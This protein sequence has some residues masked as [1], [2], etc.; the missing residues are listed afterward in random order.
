MLRKL[1]KQ[2]RYFKNI[3]KSQKGITGL[4]TAIIL[5]AFV[6]VA[7]VFAYTVLSA[8][9]F[10]TQKSQEAV[11]SGLQQT[12]S[13]LELKGSVLTN[14]LAIVNSCDTTT[15]WTAYNSLTLGTSTGTM[16]TNFVETAA[17]LTGLTT[18]SIAQNG[19]LMTHPVGLMTGLKTG[20]T[21][22][23]W[24][25]FAGT[26]GLRSSVSFGLSTADE[27]SGGNFQSHLT[28]QNVFHPADNAWHQYTVTLGTADAAALFY[29]VYADTAYTYTAGDTV[30][31][32]DIEINNPTDAS[33]LAGFANRVI[34]TLGLANGGQPID[35]TEGTNNG[36][37]Q[38]GG[39]NKI[40][41]NFNDDKQQVSDLYWT[42]AFIGSHNSANMLGPG[43]KVQITAYLDYVNKY[44]PGQA[45][46]LIANR[47]FTMEIKTTN[48]AMLTVQ[49]TMP[50]RVHLIDNLN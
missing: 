16:G 45:Y 39:I 50:V 44:A 19:A 21:L 40:V 18:V 49:R 10:S 22:T 46:K 29:G 30:Y 41:V 9:L 4:E 5:I 15:G 6:V 33:S 14:G 31:I 13:T 43:E 3:Y 27:T 32:D 37:V 25:K 20:D 34:F 42:K 2:K 7:A 48:G 35:F 28:S 11:Y 23:F 17:S 26:D 47:A 36:G 8:G 38:S 24:A 1:F 12:Q